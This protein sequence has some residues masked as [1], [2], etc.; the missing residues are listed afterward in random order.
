MCRGIFARLHPLETTVL[1]WVSRIYESEL[2]GNEKPLRYQEWHGR[3]LE[4]REPKLAAGDPCHRHSSPSALSPTLDHL[5]VPVHLAFGLQPVFK[6][7]AGFGA[8]RLVK[9]IGAS[10]DLILIGMDFSR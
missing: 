1:S 7:M 4:D 5:A 10:R 9:F 2:R 6:V 8:A 3:Q